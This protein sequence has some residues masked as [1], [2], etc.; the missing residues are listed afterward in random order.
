ML[1]R[2]VSRPGLS[3]VLFSLFVVVRIAAQG[4]PQGAA[5]TDTG[6]GGVNSI[7][8]MIVSS[9]GQRIARRVSVRLRSMTRGDRISTT[10]ESGNFV[11]RGVPPGDFIVVIEKEQDFEPFSQ[12]VSVI[13]PRGMPPQTYYLS[14][15]LELKGRAEAKPG[16]L[17]AEFINVPKPARIHYDKAVEQGKKGDHPGAIEE[18]KL[19]IK[20]YPTF[21]LAF[22]ELGVQ[23]LKLNQL[24]NADEAFQ[25]ALKITP[26][27]FAALINRG[28]ANFMM[29][30][31]GEAVPILRKALAKNDQSAVGHYF[32]GQALAN[33][34][35]FEDAEKELLASLKLGGDEMKEAH[36]ILAII[37]ASRG[38][39]KL[40]AEELEA[41]LKLA[42]DTPDAQK[43]KDKI[44]ELREPN[45]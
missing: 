36:R 2:N 22:N 19:A 29:K 42:P 32:L 13:Q 8:G 10:D 1:K 43:L 31:Y 25:R 44:R 37:Y 5:S 4:I 28:I 34:G 30:R 23:Y 33:L 35:L 26:D 6:L 16:V 9:N 12:N 45:E 15:R 17:N 38:A 24:E 20:E 21:M 39:K 14:V 18:L 41:Y 11:F 40:A 27:A 3:L 7:S